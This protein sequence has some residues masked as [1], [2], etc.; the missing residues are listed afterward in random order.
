MEP[1][2]KITNFEKDC[3]YAFIISPSDSQDKRLYVLDYEFNDYDDATN[4][5]E[6]KGKY[7]KEKRDN[8]E[9]ESEDWE[10]AQEC[11]NAYAEQPNDSPSEFERVHQGTEYLNDAE[12]DFE[13]WDEEFEWNEEDHKLVQE[14]IDTCQ[15]GLHI[16]GLKVRVH[17]PERHIHR[18]FLKEVI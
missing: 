17:L 8:S 12:N 11:R 16:V 18:Q 13:D 1:A 4:E 10:E 3:R 7:E 14:V 9:N 6:E 5:V 2:E 15:N